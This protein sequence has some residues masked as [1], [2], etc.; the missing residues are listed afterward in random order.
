M[1]WR[2]TAASARLA[3]ALLLAAAFTSSAAVAHATIGYGPEN[4]S[5]GPSGHLL[6]AGEKRTLPAKNSVS[7]SGCGTSSP[8]R[9]EGG[10]RS[11]PGEGVICDSPAHAAENPCERE[12]LAA[13]ARYHVP[14]GILYAVG[15]TE[16]GRKGSL[17]PYALNIEGRAVFARSTAEAVGLFNDAHRDG[18]MLID[19]GCM[20]INQHYH[21]AEFPSVEAMFDPHRNVD[22]AARFLVR[23]KSKHDTWS[24]AVARYH[25]GPDN[26][27]A[28]KQYVCRVIANMVAT[29]FGRWTENAKAFCSP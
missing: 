25:A 19:L 4:P 2:L 23:L 14:V 18:K 27:P 16:T 1:R 20:Q 26:D 17:Q 6:P 22:Y 7:V 8:Q 3:K 10:S 9:G 29:G 13:S 28:Q 24:M 5:S 21:G 15:L 11:E 12:I